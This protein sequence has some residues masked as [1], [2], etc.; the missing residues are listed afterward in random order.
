MDQIIKINKIYKIKLYLKD[1]FKIWMRMK[2][3]KIKILMNKINKNNKMFNQKCNKY[4]NNKI[5]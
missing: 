1:N 2:M 5:Y 3:F 4:N